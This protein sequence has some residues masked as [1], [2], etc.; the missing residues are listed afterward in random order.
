LFYSKINNENFIKKKLMIKEEN[1]PHKCMPP[2]C[3]QHS[4]KLRRSVIYKD[5]AAID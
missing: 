1:E 3:V 4:L 2:Y 5:K